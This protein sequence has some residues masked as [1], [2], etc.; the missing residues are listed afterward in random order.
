M[1]GLE[2]PKLAQGIERLDAAAR[3]HAETLFYQRTLCSLYNTLTHRRNPKLYAAFEFQQTTSYDLLLLARNLL[4]DGEVPYLE[5]AMEL[6]TQWDTLPGAKGSAYSLTF[7]AK[8]RAENK[9]DFEGVMRGMEVMQSIRESIGEL[10][11]EMGI[12]RPD[13]YDESLDA[14]AQMKEQVIDTYARTAQEREI[15]EEV[16]P[17]GT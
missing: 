11:P 15:W 8:E 6:E 2:R 14:L 3:K 5:Q 17:F 10:F 7:S 9:A 4:I 16:W 13:Q 12:V 1:V